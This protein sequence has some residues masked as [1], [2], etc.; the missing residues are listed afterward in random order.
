MSIKIA[1]QSW[2]ESTHLSKR[3]KRDE[4]LLK[5]INSDVQKTLVSYFDSVLKPLTLVIKTKFSSE[6]SEVMKQLERLLYVLF[7][8][9]D[10]YQCDVNSKIKRTHASRYSK[11][12]KEYKGSNY[13]Y[14]RRVTDTYRDKIHYMMFEKA[15][16][17]GKRKLEKNKIKYGFLETE[18][19]PCSEK[20]MEQLKL[21][22]ESQGKRIF[23]QENQ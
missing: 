5:S 19:E 7:L 20:M 3:L 14:F 6:D 2:Q 13:K 11:V 9:L 8:H 21:A 16:D 10:E 15:R 4:D 12:E 18:Q 17:D 22:E 1:I 23:S